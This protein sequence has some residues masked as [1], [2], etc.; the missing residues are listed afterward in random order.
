MA[1]S[2][3]NPYGYE[4]GA[5]SGIVQAL[6]I[7]KHML[8]VGFSLTDDAFHQIAETVRRALQPAARAEADTSTR[9]RP[10]QPEPSSAHSSS[11]SSSHS[12]SHSGSHM[13]P[14]SGSPPAMFGSTL[15]LS[16]RPFMAELWPELETVPMGDGLADSNAASAGSAEG[17]SARTSVRR[18]RLEILL[19][20]V[21]LLVSDTSC[22]VLDDRFAGA[23]TAADGALRAEIE[24]LVDELAADPLA[25]AAEAFGEVAAMLEELGM[26]PE[27]WDSRVADAARKRAA[28]ARHN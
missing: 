28:N 14:P 17:G 27:E 13:G 18:R 12:G 15:T 6:L 9:G 20:R 23:A 3:G 21:Q 24:V 10:A 22:H 16:D 1:D 2:D 25:R 5:L 8:F 7:T 11:H 4:R 26:P 19:D